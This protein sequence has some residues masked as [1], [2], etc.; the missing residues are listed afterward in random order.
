MLFAR[1][2][3]LIKFREKPLK[4]KKKDIL[5]Y[6][7]MY[8]PNNTLGIRTVKFTHHF[9][10]H[11]LDKKFVIDD[12]DLSMGNV[13]QIAEFQRIFLERIREHIRSRTSTMRH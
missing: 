9:L 3:S 10:M 1:Y 4:L 2:S 6:H 13:T 11:I 8:L 5:D 12:V 7:L